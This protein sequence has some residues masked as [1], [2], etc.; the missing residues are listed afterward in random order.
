MGWAG[1][2]VM[3]GSGLGGGLQTHSSV[4]I[5]VASVALRSSCS[6][7]VSAVHSGK[8]PASTFLNGGRGAS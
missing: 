2:R 3:V 1:M 4:V 6:D 5:P 7:V 8:A